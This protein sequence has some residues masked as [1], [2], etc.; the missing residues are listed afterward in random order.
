MLNN[1]YWNVSLKYCYP[2]H[3]QVELMCSTHET[4]YKEKHLH[5][6]PIILD[7]LDLLFG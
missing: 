1:E 2:V 7:L 5:S 3:V 6:E 4:D